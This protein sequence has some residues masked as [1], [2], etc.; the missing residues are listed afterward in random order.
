MGAAMFDIIVLN[1]VIYYIEDRIALLENLR[2]HLAPDGRLI[3]SI[4][5]HPGAVA[6][7][8]EIASVFDQ[9][10]AFVVKRQLAPRNAW[11]VAAYA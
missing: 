2:S 1:E 7:D 3:T 11:R 6:L 9:V 10:D 5:R 4:L 8:R